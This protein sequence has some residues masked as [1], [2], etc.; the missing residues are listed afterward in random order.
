MRSSN[1]TL[2][3]LFFLG[4]LIPRIVVLFHQDMLPDLDEAAVGMH[5]QNLLSGIPVSVY[6]PGQ[7]HNFLL[8]EMLVLIPFSFLFPTSLLILKIAPLIIFLGAM[9]FLLKSVEPDRR[10]LVAFLLLII[11]SLPPVILWSMKLRGGYVPALFF[12]SLI[13]WLKS[14]PRP[15]VMWDFLIGASFTWM[16]VSHFLVAVFL[17]LPI[18][19]AYIKVSFRKTEIVPG[20]L[21]A[22]VG[23]GFTFLGKKPNVILPPDTSGF[24]RPMEFINFPYDL[25]LFLSGKWSF[26][27]YDEL[28]WFLVIYLITTL[29]LLWYLFVNEGF[30]RILVFLALGGTALFYVIFQPFPLRYFI[31]LLW[32]LILFIA[33]V[34]AKKVA[35]RFRVL[36]F[37]PLFVAVLL[38]NFTHSHFDF[39]GKSITAI[40]EIQQATSGFSSVF[41]EDESLSYLLFYASNQKVHYRT[42]QAYSRFQRHWYDGEH[43]LMNNEKVGLLMKTPVGHIQSKKEIHGWNLYYPVDLKLLEN[44]NFEIKSL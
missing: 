37:V 38:D 44:L 21:G 8:L 25:S 22:L 3:L 2:F 43:A 35:W 36:L 29:F 17:L 14:R 10:A 42:R 11:C 6:F 31:P 24:A 15:R 28:N 27:H 30:H 5:V 40:H 39:D 12:A 41:V 1:R 34:P 13:I 33:L 20:I 4:L 32:A 18:L 16:I 23:W 9:F 26:F 7:A 19:Y